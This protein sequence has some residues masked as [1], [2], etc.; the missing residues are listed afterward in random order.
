MAPM[1]AVT[2]PA[3]PIGEGWS[4]EPKWDGHRVLVRR[5]GDR[6]D[7]VSSTGKPKLPQW[8]WLATAV[9]TS[10]DHDVVLDGEVIAYDDAGRHTFQSVGRADRDHAFVV[11]D[12]LALD[13][14]D[15]RDRPWSERRALL[16]SAVRP[17]SPLTITP[18]SD[19]AEVMESATRSQHFEGIVAKR[20]SSTY[21]SGR[22]APAWVKV[23]Y[24]N[25]QEMV[26]GGYKLGEGNRTGLFGSLLVGV[27]DEDGRLQFVAAVGTGFN[28]R[29]LREA[30][31][32]LRALETDAS[33]FAVPPKLPRGSYRWVRPELVA[34]VG[35]LEWTEGG[36][37]RAPV[38]LGLRDDKRPA[39]VVRE[40]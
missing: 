12:L 2:S 36:G 21:Q 15:L 22:R 39:D 9:A 6:V 8:P 35:F 17:T 5:D 4:Y 27:H 33:P 26:V 25:A 34:Q 3:V 19:D 38:F 1:K 37:I 40:S 32:K 31:A 18:V 23:K 10:T 11:F 7:A 28:E 14:E 30:M 13:G 16:E 29:T 20:T 24:T